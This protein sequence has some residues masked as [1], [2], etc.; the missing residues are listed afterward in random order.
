MKCKFVAFLVTLLFITTIRAPTCSI[1]YN[2]VTFYGSFPTKDFAEQGNLSALIYPNNANPAWTKGDVSCQNSTT[3]AVVD[4]GF[5]FT[6]PCFDDQYPFPTTPI[7]L[8]VDSENCSS[9][10]RFYYASMSEVSRHYEYKL[11]NI[12]PLPNPFQVCLAGIAVLAIAVAVLLKH[13]ADKSSNRPPKSGKPE[14][15]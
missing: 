13:F 7:I 1:G 12:T 8:K 14:S 5:T 9:C 2:H 10:E 6:T 3:P 11:R 15:H 4:C